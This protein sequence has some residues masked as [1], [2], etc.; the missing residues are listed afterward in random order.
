MR[1]IKLM[2]EVLPVLSTVGLLGLWLYQQ[3]E[4]D[5]RSRELDKLSAARS[6]FQTYQSNNALFNAIHEVIGNDASKEANLRSLQMYNYDLGLQA[7]ESALPDSA[8]KGIPPAPD[9]YSG[10]FTTQQKMNMIQTRLVVLQRKLDDCQRD[11][12]RSA[13]DAQRSYLWWYVALSMLAVLGAS[14]KVVAELR[15]SRA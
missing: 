7:I 9:A 6:V 5:R 4:I 8:R 1:A 11:I 2:G 15:D 3:T 12:A 10:V 14:S 13:E